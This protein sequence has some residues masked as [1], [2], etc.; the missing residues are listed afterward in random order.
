MSQ[1]LA[2]RRAKTGGARR[3]HRANVLRVAESTPNGPRL[4]ATDP[5]EAGSYRSRAPAHGDREASY[6]GVGRQGGGLKFLYAWQ[7]GFGTGRPN[8]GRIQFGSICFN[9]STMIRGSGLLLTFREG[10]SWPW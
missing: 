7:V 9:I 4:R 10:T 1:T 8:D 6:V 2:G 5:P 3:R